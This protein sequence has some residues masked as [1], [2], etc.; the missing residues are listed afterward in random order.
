[1]DSIEVL[2]VW[3]ASIFFIFFWFK[4]DNRKEIDSNGEVIIETNICFKELEE[5]CI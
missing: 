3:T 5:T 2:D 1:M 4:Y